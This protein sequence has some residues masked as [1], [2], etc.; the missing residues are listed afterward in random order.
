MIPRFGNARQRG[1]RYRHRPGAYAVVWQEGAVLLSRQAGP[2][3]EFQLPGGGIE[4]GETPLRALHREV[5]EETGWRIA[6][7]RRLG[8][9]RRFAYMPDHDLWAEKL[10]TVFLARPVRRLGPPTEPGYSA[11]W[12]PAARAA[13][14]VANPGDRQFLL[15]LSRGPAGGRR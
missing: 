15:G 11:V 8:A 4:E 2:V 1:R 6:V 13:A 3:P 14:S 10:C 9:F 7:S 12:M 5:A